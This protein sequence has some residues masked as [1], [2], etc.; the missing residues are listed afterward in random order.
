MGKVILICGKLCSGKTTYAQALLSQNRG[1]LL[2]SDELMHAL[3]HHQEGAL[4]DWLLPGVQAYLYQ[5]AVQIAQ[6]GCTVVLDWGFWSQAARRKASRYFEDQGVAF[7]WHY[8]DIT[9]E[10]WKENI[11][12]RNR[13]VLEGRS[14]DYFVDAGLLEKMRSLFQ[15]PQPSDMDVWHH[16]HEN[17]SR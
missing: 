4:H 16:A 13:A 7:E 17:R 9:D 14:T 6:A 15:A 12:M 5:K 3:Y 1:I 10:A 2:S 8:L 11:S